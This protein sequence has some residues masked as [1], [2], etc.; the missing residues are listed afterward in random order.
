MTRL[1]LQQLPMFQT[2]TIAEAAKDPATAQYVIDCL[3]R[4]YAGDYGKMPAEDAEAN[5]KE[6]EAGEGHILARYPAAAA[7]DEEIYIDI[8]F[9]ESKPGQ[10]SNYG[11]VMYCTEW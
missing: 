8:H 2:A 3:L 9:S 4:C 6:L 7:L 11:L 5:N 1:Q 10:G